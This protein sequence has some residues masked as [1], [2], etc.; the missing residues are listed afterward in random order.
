MGGKYFHYIYIF[1]LH[2]NTFASNFE[3]KK[4]W[5]S[6]EESSPNKSFLKYYKETFAIAALCWG[7]FRDERESR[8]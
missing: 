3:I 4:S 6:K 1:F 8:G 7:D 5:I 2:T